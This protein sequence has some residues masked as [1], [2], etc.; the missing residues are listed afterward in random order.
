MRIA[1]CPGSFDPVTKGH[2]DIIERTAKL[3]DTVTVLVVINPVKRPFFTA[4]ER[5]V[6]CAAPRRTSPMS[7]WTSTPACW[8]IMPTECRR[9]HH[10]QGPARRDG[11]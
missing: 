9:V 8:P 10:H 6:F 3:F 1:I 7:K 5:A 4:Q 11:F 2:V